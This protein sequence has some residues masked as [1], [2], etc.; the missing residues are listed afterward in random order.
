MDKAFQDALARIREIEWPPSLDTE[1]RQHNWS[2][3]DFLWQTQAV[4]VLYLDGKPTTSDEISKARE[5]G[6]TTAWGRV[7][8][9]HEWRNHPGKTFTETNENLRPLNEK[10]VA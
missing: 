8:G 1:L 7:C 9:R 6:D 3:R 4:W 10:K 5:N 2:L